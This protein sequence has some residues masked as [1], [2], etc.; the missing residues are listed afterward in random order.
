MSRVCLQQ[1]SAGAK[2]RHSKVA[3]RGPTKVSGSRDLRLQK[4]SEDAF[5]MD[6]ERLS[7]LTRDGD[8]PSRENAWS[9]P[10]SHAQ[11]TRST[12]TAAVTFASPKP[13]TIRP[14]ATGNAAQLAVSS[15]ASCF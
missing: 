13:E 4:L 2:P 8:S 1:Q 5:K 7:A 9:K 6:P 14:V 15:K 11:P 12:S 10:L 3:T